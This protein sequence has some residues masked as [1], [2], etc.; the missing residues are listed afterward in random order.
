MHIIL[1]YIIICA[2]ECLRANPED[3]GHE[4]GILNRSGV[5]VDATAMMP[6]WLEEMD[7]SRVLVCKLD[8]TGALEHLTLFEPEH[9]PKD[10][11]GFWTGFDIILANQFGHFTLLVPSDMN[12]KFPI[13]RLM[14]LAQ[15]CAGTDFWY[16]HYLGLN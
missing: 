3:A 16:H 6:I 5:F 8:S 4:P 9:G 2:G 1:Y 15:H 12:D 10:S 7:E 13:T 11:R 14:T